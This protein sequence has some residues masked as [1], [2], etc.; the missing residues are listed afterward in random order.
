MG[1][2]ELFSKSKV[3]G[4]VKYLR[5]D[6]WYCS[7][8]AVQQRKLQVYSREG[9]SLIKEDI[10]YTSQSQKNFISTIATNA[11]YHG[12]Y[13]FAIFLAEKGLNTTGSLVDQHFLYNALIEA[14]IMQNNYEKAKKYCFTELKEFPNIGK[15]LKKDFEG[16]LPNTIP[17]R[18]SLIRIVVDIEKDFE[19]GK[20]LFH[21]F[22]R[23]GLLT[24]E[25]EA[26]E[27]K[28]LRI[29]EMYAEATKLLNE[30]R[31]KDAK[32]ILDAIIETNKSQASDIYKMLA[33]YFIEKQQNEQEALK[34]Y[35]KSIRENPLIVGVKRKL[36]MLSKKLGVKVELTE[37]EIFDFLQKKEETEN[38]WWE[39]RDLANEFVK[40]K[41]Y[42]RAWGLFNEALLLRKKEGS[43]CETIYPHMAKMLEKENRYKEALLHYLITYR[44]LTIN[45]RN[46]P[47]QYVSK[48]IDRCLKK[49][50]HQSLNHSKLYSL[51]RNGMNS[52]DIQTS[53]FNLLEQK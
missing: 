13:E 38:K 53:L 50:G 25:E 16:K 2:F 17:C 39:K 10:S 8:T 32:S 35:Q 22:V 18:D 26:N 31:F 6:D 19:L 44:E 29:Q 43:T 45:V 1:L 7:L 9:E 34:Y 24:K 52:R 5:L 27:L 4:I 42:D 20:E 11:I 21:L 47:P 23:K 3:K 15:A 49:L 36:Q 48:G 30:D 46:E 28:E 40:I 37:E 12:D 51:V 14:S 41:Q 33:D